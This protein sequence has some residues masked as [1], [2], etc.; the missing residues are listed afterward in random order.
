MIL[1][2]PSA[3]PPQRGAKVF[4][5]QLDGT[6][7]KGRARAPGLSQKFSC[8]TIKSLRRPVD[9]IG[10][11]PSIDHSTD[12]STLA[13]EVKRYQMHSPRSHVLQPDAAERA[14]VIR[15]RPISAR[16][17]GLPPACT[18]TRA[19]SSWSSPSP[20][21]DFGFSTSGSEM[22]RRAPPNILA[23]IASLGPNALMVATMSW[24]RP[25]HRPRWSK[26][27]EP[28][29]SHRSTNEGR[30]IHRKRLSADVV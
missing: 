8:H 12:Q 15:Q 3:T 5:R 14:S 21:V 20:L 17:L 23:E 29:I 28:L 30:R 1:F 11:S 18:S 9:S 24:Q 25:T 7:L 19:I 16:S 13:R 22:Q 10:R 4:A 27:P 26:T 2:Q 6:E